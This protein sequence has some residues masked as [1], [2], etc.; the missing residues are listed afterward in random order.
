MYLVTP[1]PLSSPNRRRQAGMYHLISRS[2]LIRVSC[3]SVRPRSNRI[4]LCRD[5]CDII[6][7]ANESEHCINGIPPMALLIGRGRPESPAPS[8]RRVLNAFSILHLQASSVTAATE[9]HSTDQNVRREHATNRST[10]TQRCC[11]D[12]CALPIARAFRERQAQI[13]KRRDGLRVEISLN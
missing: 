9:L 11:T 3:C 8:R 1:S 6:N 12:V 4:P 7:G 5:D 10:S 2:L 13:I